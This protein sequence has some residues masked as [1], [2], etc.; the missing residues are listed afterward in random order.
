MVYESVVIGIIGTKLIARDTEKSQN[1][2]AC[3]KL[4]NGFNVARVINGN[5]DVG[6]DSITT[7]MGLLRRVQ[8]VSKLTFCLN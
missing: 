2:D 5:P 7:I 6:I 3:I 8:S 1:Q 4:V